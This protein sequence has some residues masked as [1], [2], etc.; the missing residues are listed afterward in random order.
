MMAGRHAHHDETPH[1]HEHD[2]AHDHGNEDAAP[3]TLAGH[4]H[5]HGAGSHEHG[6]GVLGWLRGTFA[7]SHSIEEQLDAALESNTLGIRALKWSLVGLGLNPFFQALIVVISGSVSLLADTIHNVGDATTSL[8]LWVA[9]AL[10]RRGASRR[11]TYGYGETEDVAAVVIVLVIFISSCIAAYEATMR[12]FRPQEV[13]YLGWVAAAAII[14]FIGNEIVA[15]FRIRA[16][17][18]IGSAALVADG[19]HARVDGFT[20]LAVLI[21]VAG[22]RLGFPILD[23]LLG[24]FFVVKDAARAVWRRLIDGIAPE[25]VTQLERAPP[26]VPGGRGAHRARARWVGHRVGA[27][28]HLAVNPELTVRVSHAIGERV[29]EALRGQIRSLGGVVIH[30]CPADIAQPTAMAQPR[31]RVAAPTLAPIHAASHER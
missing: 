29:E 25:I 2:Q 13:R 31:A 10:A 9:F 18:Q 21:G 11:F 15:Q 19:Q 26:D 7:H 24:I 8:P 30:V 20:S 27:D 12:F 4:G 14:G 1:D 5:E 16:G 3:A 17:T 22:I 23:P 6:T 28:L